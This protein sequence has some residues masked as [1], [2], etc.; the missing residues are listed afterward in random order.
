TD[1]LLPTPVDAA[2]NDR[3]GARHE[4]ENRPA[5]HA[6]PGPGLT[7][8]AQTLARVDGERDAGDGVRDARGSRERNLQPFHLEQRGRRRPAAGAGRIHA[9][10]R[11]VGH[12]GSSSRPP[13]RSASASPTSEKPMPRT[14]SASPGRVV[15]HQAF[16]WYGWPPAMIA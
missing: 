15:I 1:E 8:D 3:S 5:R 2:G 16:S 11:R 13:S 14:T 7:D 10:G 4:A 9:G 6:L 12:D